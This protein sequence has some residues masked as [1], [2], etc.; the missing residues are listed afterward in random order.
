[1]ASNNRKRD[2]HRRQKRLAKK[3]RKSQFHRDRTKAGEWTIEPL[4]KAATLLTFYAP[5]IEAAGSLPKAIRMH[6][7]CGPS[8]DLKLLASLV[9]RSRGGL[10]EHPD[11]DADWQIVVNEAVRETGYNLEATRR[12]VRELPD[13]Q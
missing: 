3:R 4:Q 8:E 10:L 11:A 9:P 13:P 2:E 1:M 12:A 6:M 5:A 7:I